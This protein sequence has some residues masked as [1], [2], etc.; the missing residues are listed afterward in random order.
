MVVTL[1][2]PEKFLSSCKPLCLQQL[3]FD[4]FWRKRQ[5]ALEDFSDLL[6]VKRGCA[7]AKQAFSEEDV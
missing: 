6:A 3:Q 1:T 5:P 2:A 7:E 4:F